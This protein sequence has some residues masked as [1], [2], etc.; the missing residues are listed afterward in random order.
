M[1]LMNIMYK[2]ISFKDPKFNT[3]L[4]EQMIEDGFVVVN[5]VF[6]DDECDD[7]V[8]KILSHFESLD[9]GFDRNNLDTWT[10]DKLPPQ[11]GPGLFHSLVSNIQPVWDIRGN[12]N[13]GAIFKT[14]Y[15][16]FKNSDINDFIVS[17][18]GINL[19]PC[20]EPY[21]NLES[22]WP[23]YDQ[24]LR[25]V[26]RCIQGQVVL[27]NTN[28]AFRCSPKS[29]RIF[30]NI[31]NL[32]NFGEDDD[33]NWLSFHPQDQPMFKQMV[34]EVGGEW[35]I[36]ILCK[37]GSFIVWSGSTI[38]SNIAQTSLM[39]PEPN[40]KYRGWRCVVYVCYRP[41]EE[42]TEEQL[43]MRS[44]VFDENRLTTHWSTVLFPK[45]P[46]WYAMSPFKNDKLLY[47][48][49]EPKRMYEKLG[50]PVLNDRQKKLAGIFSISK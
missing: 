50:K 20:I 19:R 21:A 43:N 14:L 26:F 42:F 49:E 12:K 30:N 45:F 33:R 29:H 22:D 35:Q 4:I 2:S 16:H 31:L 27:T 3:H 46:E 5:D 48:L 38:H 41:Q 24:T 11:S 1:Y 15:S 36:P 13:V 18:D 25:G 44:K 9:V 10:E 37:K 6:E 39:E 47:L 23:H 40:D 32:Y 34:K 7:Y 17:N 8:D 28:A